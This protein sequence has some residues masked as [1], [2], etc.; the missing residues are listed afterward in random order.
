MPA[1]IV[2]AD[3]LGYSHGVNLGIKKAMQQGIVTSTTLLVNRQAAGAAIELIKGGQITNVGVHLCLTSGKAL[4]DPGLIPD[5][6]DLSGEFKKRK[7]EPGTA[8]PG[9]QVER[10]LRAQVEKALAAGIDITHLDTHHHVHLNQTI[11][12][13]IAKLALEY[14]LPVRSL[15]QEMRELLQREGVKTP[16]CFIGGF[17]GEGATEENLLKLLTEVGEH[18]ERERLEFPDNCFFPQGKKVVELMVHPAIL[19]DYLVANSTYT[20]YRERELA[21]LLNR[22]VAQKITQL[23]FEWRSFAWNKKNS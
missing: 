20:T 1:L 16:D 14:D 6:V 3:D 22:E 8:M 13:V 23:G 7:V 17:F 5:L 11:L 2:N 12:E 19:D 21:V 15:H 9:N 10:E 4:T 18:F